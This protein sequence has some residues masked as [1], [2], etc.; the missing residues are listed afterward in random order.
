MKEILKKN[1]ILKK[2]NHRIKNGNITFN[3]VNKI[4]FYFFF[5]F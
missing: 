4:F 3:Y 2:E 5:S 1:E